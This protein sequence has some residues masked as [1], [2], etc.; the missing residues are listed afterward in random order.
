MG[1]GAALRTAQLNVMKNYHHP[2]FW[3]AFIL[4]GDPE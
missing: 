2:F 3:G 4:T 1:K